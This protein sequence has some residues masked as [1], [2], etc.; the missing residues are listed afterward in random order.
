MS[1]PSRPQ[2]AAVVIEDVKKVLKHLNDAEAIV[3][4]KAQLVQKQIDWVRGVA[5][6]ITEESE[7]I[8]SDLEMRLDIYNDK[9]DQTQSLANSLADYFNLH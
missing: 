5:Q 2:S 7:M 6:E 9:V 1:Y 8:V 4:K 3:V